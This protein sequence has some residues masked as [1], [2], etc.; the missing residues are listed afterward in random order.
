M[1]PISFV[2]S[3]CP[4]VST[5]VSLDEF[6]WNLVLV[7]VMKVRPE[8][9]YFVKS[10]QKYRAL[11]MKNHACFMRHMQSATI[12][13]KALM[14]FRG[15]NG[16][17]NA[18]RCS[19]IRT[20]IAYIL[21]IDANR[22]SLPVVLFMLWTKA[23]HRL[24]PMLL[25]GEFVSSCSAHVDFWATHTLIT[26]GARSVIR[27]YEN[28]ICVCSTQESSFLINEKIS[29][30]S[31]LDS[32]RTRKKCVLTEASMLKLAQD[33]RCKF[34]WRD[35]HSK[36]V[37][38]ITTEWDKSAV[39]VTVKDNCDSQTVRRRLWCELNFVKLYLH[40]AYAL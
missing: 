6:P 21:V 11:Y 28:F 7:T 40:R 16:Y 12:N 10:R 2:M 27:W 29:T 32:M 36:G 18:P 19:I 30:I 4:H 24:A 8:D 9:P 39:F 20:Y 1:A 22:Y 35:L 25:V 34:F 5:L 13:K 3:V 17:V 38:F 15:N 26:I 33:C 23:T 14:R 37:C 31:E